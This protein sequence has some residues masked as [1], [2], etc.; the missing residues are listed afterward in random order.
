MQ[1]NGSVSGGGAVSCGRWRELGAGGVAVG[2][3]DYTRNLCGMKG[4]FEAHARHVRILCGL[5]Y[6]IMGYSFKYQIKYHSLINNKTK[7]LL[8]REVSFL[9]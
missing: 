3:C 9:N 1:G 6:I 7:I 8:V 4:S 2:C 5:M